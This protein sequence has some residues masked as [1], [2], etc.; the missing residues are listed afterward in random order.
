MARHVSLLGLAVALACVAAGCSGSV[1][2]PGYF[3]VAT[4][5]GNRDLVIRDGGSRWRLP[6]GASGLVYVAIGNADDASP[7]DYDILE[8]ETC[9]ALGRVHLEFVSD[10][11]SE[12][13]VGPTGD[14]QSRVIESSAPGL[15]H[16]EMTELC[17]RPGT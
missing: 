4:N 11:V 2:D 5:L 14:V 8:P 12:L 9:R 16:L 13:V 6:A 10:H 17:P 15:E 7:V 3:A 1:S